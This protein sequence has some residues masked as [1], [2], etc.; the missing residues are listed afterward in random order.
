MHF[1]GSGVASR[2]GL[3]KVRIVVLTPLLQFTLMQILDHLHLHHPDA[4]DQIPNKI[5][6]LD[7]GLASQNFTL[8]LYAYGS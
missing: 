2:L 5:M 3:L 6:N 1:D 8:M 4:L 7:H